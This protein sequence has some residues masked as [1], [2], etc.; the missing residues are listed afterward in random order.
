MKNLVMFQ[1][2]PISSE[3]TNKYLYNK[4]RGNSACSVLIYL[5]V[6]TRGGS[7]GVNDILA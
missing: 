2:L 4:N 5:I 3:P 7:N 1:N 6:V